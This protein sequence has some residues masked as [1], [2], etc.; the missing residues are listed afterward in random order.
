M[1]KELGIIETLA[2]IKA[3][4]TKKEIKAMADAVEEINVKPDA[5][6]ETPEN[7]PK[8]SVAPEVEK[9]K[10]ETPEAPEAEPDYKQM[11]EEL[12]TKYDDLSE[13]LKAAQEANITKDVSMNTSEKV[14]AQQ[15]VDKI[16][17]EIL[18]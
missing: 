4:Y 9:T 7:A 3:G 6:E 17:A 12:Q 14:T 18:Y 8:E 5:V 1:A 15:T 13:K 2:L 16:F 11:F 10:V